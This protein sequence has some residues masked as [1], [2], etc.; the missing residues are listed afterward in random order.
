[1]LTGTRRRLTKG[2]RLLAVAGA[3]LAVAGG[4]AYASIPG[5]GG[6]ISAC[7]A[8][9]GL[10]GAGRVR[11]IDAEAGKRCNAQENPLSWNQQGPPGLQGPQGAPG[12]AGP[13]GPP[14][15]QGQ[16][17]PSGISALEIVSNYN[18]LIDTNTTRTI[19]AACPPPKKAIGGGYSFGWTNYPDD[20]VGEGAVVQASTYGPGASSWIVRVRDRSWINAEVISVYALCA[21]VG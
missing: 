8:K 17:G 7:Y 1:M 2:P 15:P 18:N 19:S 9:D 6:V 21:N 20:D 10:P 13:Q 14:G 4:V 16:Q 5:S 12:P 3:I 11:V